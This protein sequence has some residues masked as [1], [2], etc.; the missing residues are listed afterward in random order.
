MPGSNSDAGFTVASVALFLCLSYA[1]FW[2]F[3]QGFDRGAWAGSPAGLPLAAAF[4]MV[5]CWTFF[6]STFARYLSAL[7]P[8]RPMLL[9]TILVL[10]C[11]FLALFPL[12]HWAIAEAID[13]NLLDE[14]RKHGPIT[15]A[16]SPVMA[17]LSSL[18]LR[19]GRREFPL[20]AGSGQ[21][22]VAAAFAVFALGA[23]AAFYWLGNRARRR[24][25]KENSE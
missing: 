8:D 1:A 2:P 24:I 5:L 4:L 6:T 18:D 7:L 3:L 17:I 10:L 19:A 12:V 9:R 11:L 15:L 20:Y 21:I 23:G 22:P 25:A 14:E 13:R 16:L